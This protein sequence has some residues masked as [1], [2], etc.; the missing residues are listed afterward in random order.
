MLNQK[1]LS[2][3]LFP[4]M[5]ATWGCSPAA[6]SDGTGGT[7]VGTGGSSTGT[8]GSAT[9]TGGSTTGTGGS[10]A[11]TGGRTTGT[12]G[13]VV[14]TGGSTPGTGG[15]TGTGG[16]GGATG[17]GGTP[18]TGGVTVSTGPCDIWVAP[19]GIDTNPGT[20]A[21]PVLTPQHAYDLVCPPTAGAVNGDV[22][23]GGLSSM[24]LKAGTYVL[25]TRI[26]FKKTRMGTPT[27][28]I[29]MMADPAATTKPILDF[30]T[31]PRLACGVAPADK[32]RAGVD[33][34]ADWYRIKGLEI[35]GSNDSGVLVQGAHDFVEL[36][37]IHDNADTGLQISS[38]SG[39]AG[40]GT[41]NTILNSDSYHNTDP[42]CMGAN[43]DGFGAKEGVG[44]GNSFDGC[45]A[46]DNADDGWDFFG[47]ASP[48]SVKNSWA[49]NQGATTAQ[50]M[51]NGNGFKMGGNSVSA[52]HT[53][54]NLFAFD[55]NGNG[56]HKSDWGFTNNSNPAP[57]TCT[58]CGAWNN[59]GGN[60]QIIL[61][62]GDVT[63]TATS[64]RAVAAQRTAT[65]ALPPITSI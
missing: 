30:S 49:F 53:M 18:G 65:G 57:M 15:V 59:A 7:T 8:G 41:N 46:W 61:H 34:G 58:G 33:M 36:C 9:G 47:W 4:L 26:E 17:T 31:Q 29:T 25:G 55:N 12:G 43:A 5:A 54:S 32:N 62:T 6:T 42:Q 16:R 51:S 35:K 21:M 50:S 3:L 44:A 64:A 2:T 45:R 27:R 23:G 63:A 13:S 39:F 22:C 60:F 40:S 48:I 10:T 38:G 11:G 14:G 20:E 24:C 28:I 37:A 1:R 19:N 56:G 52:A